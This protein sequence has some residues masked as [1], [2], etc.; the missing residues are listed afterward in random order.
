[1]SFASFR[2]YATT[3][4]RVNDNLPGLVA[5]NRSVGLEAAL[6]TPDREGGDHLSLRASP[7][8]IS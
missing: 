7:I 8:V 6:R 1:M 5:G 2:E 4:L 3:G